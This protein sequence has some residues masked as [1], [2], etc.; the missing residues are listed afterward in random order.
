[1]LPESSNRL[2]KNSSEKRPPKS[3]YATLKPLLFISCLFFSCFV[4]SQ[5]GINVLDSNTFTLGEGVVLS[6]TS[7]R[8]LSVVN[9][10]TIWVSGS[11]G[12]IA[13]STDGGKTFHYKQLKGYE[14]SDFRDIEAF[15]G[16][17]AVIMS[18][19]TPAYILKTTDG[20]QTW[21]E[22]YK[23]TDSA[24]FLDAMDFWN[25]RNGIL[26]GDPVN[27]HFMLMQTTDGGETWREL[28]TACTPRATDGEAI[29]AASGTSLRCLN[30][31]QYAFVTGGSVSR[32]FLLKRGSRKFKVNP[33]PVV[34]G[35]N[36]QGTFSF[37]YN[38]KR[39]LWLF[40]GGD[41]LNDTQTTR[42]NFYYTKTFSPEEHITVYEN[43]HGYKSCIEI[44]E[45]PNGKKRDG[46]PYLIATG[47]S[48]SE[49]GT[50]VC[51]YISCEFRFK[52]IGEGFH[53]VQKAK[54]GNA[55]FLAGQGGKIARLTP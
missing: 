35:Q 18:S 6:K 51:S 22:V 28:D 47:T 55:V 36:S 31:N 11:R 33:I 41:Y 45:Y 27:G 43:L 50:L 14:R 10:N 24:Y 48:G 54:K 3:P 39:S 20:G 7:F 53:V 5:A 49:L 32:M 16:N 26:V 34:Q 19:G 37:A 21:K 15:D 30:S 38:G 40:A 2:P 25:D 12:T 1:M 8:G 42:A 17:T 46:Y 44:L 9:N 23:N 29:F 13:R 52:R 4:Y